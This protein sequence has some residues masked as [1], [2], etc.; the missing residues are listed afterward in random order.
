MMIAP[1]RF[2][3]VC[4]VHLIDL[5]RLRAILADAESQSADGA[6]RL[7]AASN[8]GEAEW[9]RGVEAAG[10]TLTGVKCGNPSGWQRWKNRAKRASVV[11]RSV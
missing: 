11:T 6:P 9:L 8:E 4:D 5:C 1:Q 3:R 10:T 7:L 2:G